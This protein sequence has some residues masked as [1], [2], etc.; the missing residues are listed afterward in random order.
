MFLGICA[1]EKPTPVG[2]GARERSGVLGNHLQLVVTETREFHAT[3]RMIA[4]D[5]AFQ[6]SVVR[7]FNVALGKWEKDVLE[8][9]CTMK[10]KR[11]DVPGPV[12]GAADT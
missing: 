10:A 8:I 9:E 11:G 2:R 6:S 12:R 7:Q 5:Q 4:R 3:H 1:V